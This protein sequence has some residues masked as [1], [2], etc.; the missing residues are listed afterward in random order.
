[1]LNFH[2]LTHKHTSNFF[3]KGLT[4]IHHLILELSVAVH[5][6]L[7][8]SLV[9]NIIIANAFASQFLSKIA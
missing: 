3:E 1:M 5:S 8:K 9:V 2:L 4:R 6:S 7:A